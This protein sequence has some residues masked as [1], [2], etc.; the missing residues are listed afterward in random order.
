M[1]FI[2][3]FIWFIYFILFIFMYLFF[4]EVALHLI[5]IWK[6]HEFRSVAI[7]ICTS[8]SFRL[9]SQAFYEFK[10]SKRISR[11]KKFHTLALINLIEA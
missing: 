1:Q 3:L 2:Y 4:E 9:E 6:Y 5:G 8:K 7:F 10:K 11:S